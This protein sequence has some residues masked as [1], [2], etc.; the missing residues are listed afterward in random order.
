MKTDVLHILSGLE[1][2]GAEVMLLRL[3]QRA[4]QDKQALRHHV[5]SLTGDSVGIADDLRTLGVPLS[6]LHLS[7]RRPQPAYIL[8]LRRI[9]RSVQPRVIQG[10]M[11]HGNVA[12]TCA[13]RIAPNSPA[14]VWNV[15]HS[16]HELK[17]ERWKVRLSIWLNR[18]WSR[19]AHGIIYNSHRAAL[20]H[21]AYGFDHR[22]THVIPNGFD[23][24][25]A[26][27]SSHVTR[28]TV[29][30][31]AF[32]FGFVGRYHHVKG[33]D[34]FLQALAH[35]KTQLDRPVHAIL[36]GRGYTQSNPELAQL[37]E[38]SGLTQCCH[39]LGEVSDVPQIMAN[40]DVVVSAS[41]GEG[42][43]NVVGEAM[44]AARPCIVT[45][46][47]DSARL[48]GDAGMVVP[49][50]NVPELAQAMCEFATM[51][52]NERSRLG[53]LGRNRIEQHYSLESVY[54]QYHALYASL[55]PAPVRRPTHKAF[56]VSG[57]I[58][59]SAVTASSH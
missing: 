3:L 21:Q 6:A 32:V 55:L 4:A 50:S 45:D 27:A 35:A 30:E 43:P 42:F 48:L 26:L 7:K 11:Y 40:M 20:Q 37:L 39:L 5:L 14:L 1:K 19:H 31:N 28:P 46:V 38:S 41:R 54:R 57:S 18:Y 13:A 34:L 36:A 12:A 2:G 22:S 52:P 29:P 17:Q 51:S 8:R 59:S 56:D 33:P 15:R 25:N 24:S 47:G 58:E 44:L 9:L 10:W 23:T 16:L 49:P 53:R